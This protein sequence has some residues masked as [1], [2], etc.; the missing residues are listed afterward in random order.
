MNIQPQINSLVTANH[1]ERALAVL[2]DDPNVYGAH[3]HLLFWL[4]KGMAAHLAGR[5]QVSIDAFEQAE[6]LNE[7][8]YTRSLS[9]MANTWIV[10]DRMEDYRGDEQEYVMINVFQ[11]FNFASIG[12]FDEALVEARRLDKKLKLIGPRYQNP[13]ALFLSGLLWHCSTD[14]DSLTDALIDYQKAAAAYE[15]APRVLSELMEEAK[16]NESFKKSGKAR[17]IVVEY[18]G[19]S[20]V[21]VADAFPLPLDGNHWTKISFPRYQDR[22]SEIVFSRVRIS[23]NG[24]AHVK[25]TE[26]VCDLGALAKKILAGHKGAIMA[27]ATIRPLIKYGVEKAVEVPVRERAGDLAADL[28]GVAGSIYNLATE[29]A[30]L[31]TWQSLPNHIRLAYV[32]LDPGVYDVTVEDLSDEMVV[33]DHKTI[34]KLELSSGQVK[35][36][37]SRGRF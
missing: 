27:K 30:D 35:F 10:N 26:M 7:A 23:R 1:V 13:F 34:E 4:D 11:A 6:K 20:P 37:I 12:D 21:K 36:I 28:L 24:I 19:F 14:K 8:L 15:A 18:T 3:D 9:Q 33:I 25:E 2:G 29:E 31:R 5:T 17:V 22:Y 32:D 16:N